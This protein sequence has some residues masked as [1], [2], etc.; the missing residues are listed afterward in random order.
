MTERILWAVAG[1]L[2][3]STFLPYFR[4]RERP[5]FVQAYLEGAIRGTS[6]GLVIALSLT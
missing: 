3:L 6:L 5:T 2:I 1:L 4:S